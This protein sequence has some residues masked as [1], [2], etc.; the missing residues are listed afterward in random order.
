MDAFLYVPQSAA[1]RVRADLIG[2]SASRQSRQSTTLAPEARRRG[3]RPQ[4]GSSHLRRAPANGLVGIVSEVDDRVPETSFHAS[5]RVHS[6]GNWR[7]WDN[8]LAMLQ[9]TAVERST[10]KILLLP[11]AGLSGAAWLRRQPRALWLRQDVTAVPLMRGIRGLAFINSN[12][13][14]E[15]TAHLAVHHLERVGSREIAGR[16]SSQFRAAMLR[17]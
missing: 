15:A 14:S 5:A 11:A 16:I 2:G 13:V 17:D 1:A 4:D 8:E 6:C 7:R 3:R 10:E 9:N 12:V